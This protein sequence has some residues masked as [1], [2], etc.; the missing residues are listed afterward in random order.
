MKYK[1][2]QGTHCEGN[3]T[4]KRGDVFES[5]N[6]NLVRHNST[7][8]IRFEVVHESVP[9]K[10]E[11]KEKE[12]AKEDA[13]ESDISEMTVKQL[14]EFAEANNIDIKDAVKKQELV[15]V[16]QASI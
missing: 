11:L 12:N 5:A 2:L 6:E 4:F 7:G 10:Q 1:L 13:D 9:T 16:I 8:S 3:Q 14:H 15:D